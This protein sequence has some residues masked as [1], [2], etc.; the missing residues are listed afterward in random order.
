[1]DKWKSRGGKSQKGEE[2][3]REDQRRERVRRKKMQ[4]REKVKKSWFTMFFPMICGCGG[5][6]SRLAK[7]ARSNLARWEMKNCTLLWRE[8]H[9]QVKNLKTHHVR[10]TLGSWDVEALHAIVA[11]S[12]FPSQN[13]QSTSVSEHLWNLR[14]RKSGRRCGAKR[15]SKSKC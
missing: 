3:K 7:A 4:V 8:A 11:G 2:Q 10:S 9:L 15:V 14:C 1:M 12:T 5:S 13:V 6:K